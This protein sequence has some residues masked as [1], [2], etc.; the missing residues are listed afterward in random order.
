M[1]KQ[2]DHRQTLH[3]WL[4]PEFI[5][6][7][8]GP[9]WYIVAA[10]IFTLLIIYA[11]ASQSWTMA[12]AFLVVAIIFMMVENRAP[13]MLQVKITDLG[14]FYKGQF[15]AYHEI[16]AFWIVY[17]PP[18]VDAL[19]LRIRK[20][21]HYVTLKIQLNGENP[22]EIRKLLMQEIPEI[23]GAREPMIDLLIRLL[24]LH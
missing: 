11:L 16:N 18:F 5:P 7:P 2:I 9:K 1:E 6:M 17:H 19:Y 22:I 13:K 12:L 20:K 3:Q 14:I 21:K 15:Y 10:I 8:R 4:A 24:R 23:E